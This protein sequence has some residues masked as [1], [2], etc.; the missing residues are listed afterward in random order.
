[1]NGEIYLLNKSKIYDN[2]KIIASI[3]VFDYV[4]HKYVKETIKSIMNQNIN[5]ESI[6]IIILTDNKFENFSY[7]PENIPYIVIYTGLINIGESISL[8]INLSRGEIIFPI[9]NDDLWNENRIKKILDIFHKY[10]NLIFIKNEIKPFGNIKTSLI[11]LNF[12]LRMNIPKKCD[13][14]FYILNEKTNSKIYGRALTHNFSSMAFKKKLF[15]N[16]MD[17]LKKLEFWP[18]SYT[19][20]SAILSNGDVGFLDD[21]LTYYRIGGISQNDFKGKNKDKLKLTSNLINIKFNNA[22]EKYEHNKYIRYLFNFQNINFKILL[23]IR[24]IEK[25]EIGFNEIFIGFLLSIKLNK[26][27]Q[28]ILLVLAFYVKKILKYDNFDI[29]KREGVIND[30]NTN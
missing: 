25:V 12:F 26:Y 5:F 28:Y 8:G 19:F 22:F 1:M 20:W 4:N 10:P 14:T 15:L 17:N 27:I 6:E 13:G 21:A 9:D 30:K 16:D 7:I 3:I 18:D 24:G 29:F 11:Q 2:V 23:N